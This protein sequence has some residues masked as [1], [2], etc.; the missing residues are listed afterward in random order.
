MAY[1]DT[2]AVVPARRRQLGWDGIENIIVIALM[3][4]AS[5]GG[6]G[7]QLPPSQKNHS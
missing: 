7:G 1:T 4:V 6:G 2:E 5:G 3:A